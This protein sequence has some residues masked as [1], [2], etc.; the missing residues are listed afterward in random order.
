MLFRGKSSWS[1]YL[2]VQCWTIVSVYVHVFFYLQGMV[3]K[4]LVRQDGIIKYSG[5]NSHRSRRSS[6]GKSWWGLWMK[7]L[8][9]NVN[10]TT[11][12][13]MTGKDGNTLWSLIN[14]VV[15]VCSVNGDVVINAKVPGSWK[16]IFFLIKRKH[17]GNYVKKKSDF[18]DKMSWFQ[19]G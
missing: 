1:L 9:T 3:G 14:T 7:G 13:R 18:F 5:W 11:R 12:D 2:Y 15:R 8:C 19:L 10:A 17:N 6:M 16:L 4:L